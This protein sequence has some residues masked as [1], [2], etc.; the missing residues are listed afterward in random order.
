MAIAYPFGDVVIIFFIVLAIRGM[1]GG[2]RL[3][4]WCLLGGL[5]AIALSDSAYTYLTESR[6]MRAG[7]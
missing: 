4:L 3:A 1:T 5:L 2:D 6:V 7:T